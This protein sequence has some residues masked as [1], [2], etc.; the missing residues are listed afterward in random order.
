MAG[1]QAGGSEQ[2]QHGQPA[3]PGD[4]GVVQDQ[5]AA[6]MVLGGQPGDVRILATSRC[7]VRPPGAQAP[8]P[9]YTPEGMIGCEI[10]EGGGNGGR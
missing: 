4:A 9:F 6:G 7:P 3:R 2:G 5:Q 10:G 1:C 8:L